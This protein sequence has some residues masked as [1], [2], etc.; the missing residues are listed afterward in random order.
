MAV[1]KALKDMAASLSKK[2]VLVI[3]VLAEVDADDA[4]KV[5]SAQ[6]SAMVASSQTVLQAACWQEEDEAEEKDE[7]KCLVTMLR[8]HQWKS[9]GRK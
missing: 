1:K 2:P 5:G 6:A 7:D 9:Y 3:S 8:G 4:V